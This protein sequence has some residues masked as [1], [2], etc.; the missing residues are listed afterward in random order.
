[1]G[2]DPQSSHDSMNIPKIE[3]ISLEYV[4][5]YHSCIFLQQENSLVPPK[6]PVQANTEMPY[7]V[8]IYD[9]SGETPDDLSFVSGDRIELLEH[10][11]AD[12]LKGSLNGRTGMFPSAFVEIHEDVTGKNHGYGGLKSP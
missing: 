10:V 1:M 8:A 6:S 7:C 3:F 4:I 5:C 9:F 2:L 11:G 12:W